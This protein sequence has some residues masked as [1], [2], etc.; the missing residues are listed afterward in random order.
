[1]DGGKIDLDEAPGI[2]L[3]HGHVD[4][5]GGVR[6]ALLGQRDAGVAGVGPDVIRMP[7][8]YGPSEERALLAYCH[9]TNMNGVSRLAASPD[10][11]WARPVPW[12]A[13]QECTP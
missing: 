1:V 7:T 13:S 10:S 5:A 9:S 6:E 8:S 4:L 12:R 2:E 3:K 11:P